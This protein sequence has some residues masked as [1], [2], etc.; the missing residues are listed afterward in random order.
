MR[1]LALRYRP[2]TNEDSPGKKKESMIQAAIQAAKE[3]IDQP[4]AARPRAQ[5]AESNGCREVN[6]RQRV[7]YRSLARWV[8]VN[9][10]GLDLA[11][12]PQ[13]GSKR[14]HRRFGCWREELI[15]SKGG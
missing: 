14:I 1:K 2:E 8:K 10:P 4:I 7:A 15:N 9:P 11:W 6:G 3:V 12:E 13:S 5:E